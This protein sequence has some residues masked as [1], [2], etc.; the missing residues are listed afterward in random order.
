MAALLLGACSRAASRAVRVCVAATTVAARRQ[1]GTAAA[2]AAAAAP[3]PKG[4]SKGKVPAGS[5]ALLEDV[6][7]L[8]KR[9]GFVFPGSDLYGS[10]GTG[11]DYGPLGVALKR[12]LS[13]AWWRAFVERRP[14][15]VGIETALIMNPRVWEASGHVGL[16]VDPLTECTAC[17]KRVRADKLI[18]S[19]AAGVMAA[20]ASAAAA[21]AAPGSKSG[22]RAASVSAEALAAATAVT[23]DGAYLSSRSLPQLHDIMKAL[24]IPC[25]GCGVP[26]AEGRGLGAPRMFNLLF[27]TRVGPHLPGDDAAA[28]AAGAPGVAVADNPNRATRAF[29]R[30]ETAQGAYVMFANLMNTTRRRLPLGVGQIGKSFR[31]EVA[32]GN[33]IFRTREFEQME[34]QYF[35]DPAT[36]A[37][38]FDYWVE[39]AERWLHRVGLSPANIRRRE[40]GTKVRRAG[41]RVG[42]EG[43]CWKGANTA[44]PRRRATHNTCRSLRTMPWQPRTW[45]TGTRLGGRNCGASPTAV[46][47]T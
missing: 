24:G 21:A 33:F 39:F 5:T 1:A 26:T 12:N 23:S 32:V 10:V 31:N 47:T 46:T 44:T 25:P 6:V 37:R 9:R 34:M 43:G 16:F 29:L 36:S 42:G 40:Y 30:P 14:D 45:S 35:C 17:R 41:P 20:A 15:A 11:Y 13:D 18:S 28:A 7:A 8:C 2:A 27:E 19:A 4:S 38:W 3:A 22:S